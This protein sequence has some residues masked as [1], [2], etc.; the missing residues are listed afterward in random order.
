MR[1]LLGSKVGMWHLGFWELRQ[2]IGKKMKNVP[3]FDY[4]LFKLACSSRSDSYDQVNTEDSQGIKKSKR[5]S[6]YLSSDPF[7]KLIAA[8][9]VSAELAVVFRNISKSNSSLEV[10]LVY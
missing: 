5:I 6:S 2:S 8:S 7:F 9:V 4:L 1:I 10:T 3:I